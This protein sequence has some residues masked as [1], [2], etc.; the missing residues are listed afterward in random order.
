MPGEEPFATKT[1]LL[2]N[3][4]RLR[5]HLLVWRYLI[6]INE[7]HII[8]HMYRRIKI[9]CM[10]NDPPMYSIYCNRNQIVSY[11]VTPLS[12]FKENMTWVFPPWLK[13]WSVATRS[14]PTNRRIPTERNHR[15]KKKHALNL[16]GLWQTRTSPD[17]SLAWDLNEGMLI[18]GGLLAS[19]AWRHDTY[20]DEEVS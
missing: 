9:S 12:G 19:R 13:T 7:E 14:R 11:T 17:W 18:K 3:F 6:Y 4:H 2:V 15:H 1:P 5:A 20:W 10:L 8:K 16:R